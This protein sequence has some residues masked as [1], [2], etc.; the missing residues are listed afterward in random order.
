M[1]SIPS[2]SAPAARLG[3]LGQAD[4]ENGKLGVRILDFD[5]EDDVDVPLILQKGD[6][7]VRIDTK[8]VST[9]SQL[10]QVLQQKKPKQSVRITVLRYGQ[11][12]TFDV[13][14]GK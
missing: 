1:T 5:T 10:R 13:I 4:E 2:V 6:L 9:P 12:L 14:L 7:I 11:E 8:E 3:I